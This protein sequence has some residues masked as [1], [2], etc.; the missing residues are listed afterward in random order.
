MTKFKITALTIA[1]LICVA[2]LSSSAA[3]QDSVERARIADVELCDLLKS[4]SRYKNRIV[5]LRAVYSSWFEGSEFVSNC[6]DDDGAVWL[7]WERERGRV[8]SIVC[9]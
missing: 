5:R 9:D 4:A 6:D 1:S 8:A 7:N 2:A 3:A